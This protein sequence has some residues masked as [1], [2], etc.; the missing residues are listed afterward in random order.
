MNKILPV[1]PC[2]KT[3]DKV[4]FVGSLDAAGCFPLG[5]KSLV[6]CLLDPERT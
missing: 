2:I 3:A 4:T 1:A 6:G 5:K